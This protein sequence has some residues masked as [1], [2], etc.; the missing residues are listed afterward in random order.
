MTDLPTIVWKQ[1]EGT[2]SWNGTWEDLDTRIGDYIRMEA[3][4][5]KKNDRLVPDRTRPEA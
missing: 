5:G 1:S 2:I 4:V 3:Y